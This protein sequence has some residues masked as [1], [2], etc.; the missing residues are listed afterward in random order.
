[1]PKQK[2]IMQNLRG[3]KAAGKEYGKMPALKQKDPGKGKVTL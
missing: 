1:L 2:P 3:A